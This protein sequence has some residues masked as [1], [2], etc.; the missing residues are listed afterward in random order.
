MPHMD[1]TVPV[2]QTEGLIKV[3][4]KGEA[5]FTA[6]DAITLEIKKGESIAILGKS[7]SGKSTLMHILA[8]LDSPTQGV[9]SIDGTDASRLKAKQLDLL[10]NR[11][12]GFVFQQFYL[13]ANQ[14]LLENVMLPLKTVGV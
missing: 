9:V 10:R 8:L 1:K 13:N 12:F 4:G 7:G 5:A 6:L 11:R 14:S 3:Y 2:L